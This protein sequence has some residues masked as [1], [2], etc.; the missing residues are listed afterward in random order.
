MA[1][2]IVDVFLWG[3]LIGKLA[4]EGEQK[5]VATF[6][7]MEDFVNSNISLSPLRVPNSKAIHSFEDISYRTFHG[8]P[9]FIADSLP[10]KFGNQLI[11]Q[12][13]ANKG[14]SE[15]DITALDRLLYVGN[16]SM[17]ALE[18]RPSVELTKNNGGAVLNLQDLA[19]LSDLVTNNKKEFA[20]KLSEADKEKAISLLRIGSSAGGARAKALVA[21]DENGNFY[22]GTVKQHNNAEYYLLKFDSEE[23]Q[24]R[25]SKDPKGMT[26][27]EYIY[28]LIAKEC[29][30]DIPDTLYSETNGGKDFHYLIKRFDRF[31]RAV[32]REKTGLEKLHY[33][34]WCGMA[35]AHRDTTGAYSYEQLVL[36]ARELGL[37]QDDIAEIFKRAVFNIVGRNQDDHTKNFGFLMDK[38][39]EWSLAPA[40]D[41]TY[42]YDPYGKWTREHQIKCNNKQDNFVLDDFIEFGKKCN[43]KERVVI[44]ILQ[45]TIMEFKKFQKLSKEYKV[46]LELSETVFSNMRLGIVNTIA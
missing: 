19:E 35:H 28:S 15:K 29:G 37:K 22:D 38:S 5:E 33:V 17:G 1:T 39:G 21:L 40:F 26:R 6:E 8:L 18:Y 31:Y 20:K 42:S 44:K 46:P 16:R 7:Y 43:I 3:T 41:L 27:V 4:Y 32:E 34:S 11:D 25:D 13:F 12:Y 24:D 14:I 36:T 9:G 2:L 30:I 10:D 23:N 45:K